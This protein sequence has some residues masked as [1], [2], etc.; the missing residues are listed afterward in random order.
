MSAVWFHFRAEL[1]TRWRSWLAMAVLVAISAGV[2][3]TV[4]A[5]ARRADSAYDRFVAASNAH[6]VLVFGQPFDVDL[7]AV[8]RLP[9]VADSARLGYALLL[10]PERGEDLGLTPLVSIDGGFFGRIDRPKI[11]EGRRPDPDRADEVAIT[12]PLARSRNLGVGSTM[13]VKS[14]SPEQVAEI[15]S[16]TVSGAG[17]GPEVVL[18]VVGIE[19]IA[20]E[21]ELVDSEG[22]EV[23]L[24]LTPAFARTYRDAIGMSPLLAVR[25][26]RGA[27]DLPSFRAGVER[28]GAG[29]PVQMNSQAEEG[30]KPRPSIQLQAVA[31]SLFA[32]L[33]A[34]A[35]VLALGQALARQAF[36]SAD[37]HPALRAL[38]MTGGQLWMTAMLRAA[39]IG[40]VGAAVAVMVAVMASPLMPLGLAR[41]TEPSPGVSVDGLVLGL[42]LLSCPCWCSPSPRCRRGER[43]AV[44]RGR[45]TMP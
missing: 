18:Q 7:D 34:L 5:G 36:T 28:I 3:L 1:R 2:V 19:A 17:A 45:P 30:S 4:A 6:D 35:A 23:N 16:G 33:A 9:E 12:P 13:T 38:G 42:G 11:L 32:G 21:G 20:A 26:V 40:V 31:L 44:P 41:L 8:A 14:F 27:A 37:D 29:Q 39:L 22:S 43:P 25:L 15:F 10:E 24:H